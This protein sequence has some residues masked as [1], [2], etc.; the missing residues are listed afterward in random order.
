VLRGSVGAAHGRKICKVMDLARRNGAPIIGL[1][2]SGGARTLEGVD[3]L[4]AC[5]EIFYRWPAD[6]W[7]SRPGLVIASRAV[8]LWL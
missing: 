5:G 4:A 7:N 6:C 1:I 2:D 3:S 8:G